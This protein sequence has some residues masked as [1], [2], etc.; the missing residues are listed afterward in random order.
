MQMRLLALVIAALFVSAGSA[1]AQERTPVPN[2]GMWAIGGAIGAGTPS[3]PSLSGGLDMT[4][5]I[6]RFLTPRFALRGQFGGEWS[7]IVNRGFTGTI[8]PVFLDGNAVYNFEGGVWHPYITGGLGMYRYRAFE[9]LAP[10]A[11]DT[12]LGLN[13]GGGLEYFANRRVTVTGEILFH[14]IGQVATPLTTFNKGQF[15][16]FTAGLKRYF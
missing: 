14:D 2:T 9:N 8:S 15:W 6:E 7:D 11:T 12:T 3:D 1:V 4:G 5:N 13:V 16:T 10:A